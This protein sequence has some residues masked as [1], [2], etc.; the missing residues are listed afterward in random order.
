MAWYKLHKK[1]SV[2]TSYVSFSFFFSNYIIL[3]M[4]GYIESYILSFFE[5]FFYEVT[6]VFVSSM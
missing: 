2:N 3:F 1:S 5:R 6:D 4:Y